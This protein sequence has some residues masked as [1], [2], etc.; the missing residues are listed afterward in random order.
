M[1]GY[2]KAIADDEMVALAALPNLASLTLSEVP[3]SHRVIEALAKSPK[4]TSLSLRG[5]ER[6]SGTETSR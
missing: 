4:L 5:P 1:Y 6:R 2:C 3:T